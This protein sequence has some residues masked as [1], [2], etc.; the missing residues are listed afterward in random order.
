[1]KHFLI[2][3]LSISVFLTC[4]ISFAQ[5]VYRNEM[6]GIITRESYEE[7]ILNGPY[8]GVPGLD[9]ND[10]VLIHR[11]PFGQI[12]NPEVFYKALGLSEVLKEGKP[13]VVIFYP[14]KDECNSTGLTE[15]NTKFY[16]KDQEWLAKNIAKKGGYGP[17]Y[18]YKNPSGLEKYSGIM[19]W[20]PDP[21]GLFEQRFFKFPYPCRSFVVIDPSGNYRAILGEF[22]NS[23]IVDALKK[24]EKSR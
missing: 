5:K 17:L 15:G 12:D 4:Q 2:L 11:M 13:I 8:F 10:Q 19:T 24:L 9:E 16:Q 14:G 20:A 6:G 21:E 23:Q 7:Q 1:M 18:I 3:L 22:P